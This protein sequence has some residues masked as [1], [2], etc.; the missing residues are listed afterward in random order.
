MA[1]RFDWF[2]TASGRRVHVLDPDPSLIHVD[3]IAHALAHVCR[4]GG[5]VREFYSVAQHSVL[6]SELV[7]EEHALLGLMHDATEAYLGDVIRPLKRL[8]PAYSEIEAIWEAA[9]AQRF[10]LPL[11]HPPSIKKAD[12]VALVTERRDLVAIGGSLRDSRW[13]EDELGH[14][15]DLRRITSLSPKEARVAFLARFDEL[16]RPRWPGAKNA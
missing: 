4:F 9:I 7:P 6:V 8:L 14:S 11:D 16:T 12:V 15:P 5:H 1:D 13:K 3:D 10:G 2:I